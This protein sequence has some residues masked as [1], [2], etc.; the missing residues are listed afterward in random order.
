ML[1][2]ILAAVVLFLSFSSFAHAMEGSSIITIP[3]VGKSDEQFRIGVGTYVSTASTLK[4]KD[5]SMHLVGSNNYVP[6]SIELDSSGALSFVIEAKQMPKF[7]W[8]YQGGFGHESKREIDNLS[9][10]FNGQNFGAACQNACPTL[11]MNYAFANAVYRF[12]QVYIPV[13]LNFSRPDYNTTGNEGSSYDFDGR[14]GA[15]IGVG[16]T[17]TD[18]MVFELMARTLRFEAVEKTDSLEIN[19][20]TVSMTGLNFTGKYYF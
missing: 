5:A 20:E 7:G 12:D 11:T 17:A 6:A 2:R 9:I 14:F 1:S 10:T 3:T 16:L 4:A 15:Q 18:N 19:Y 8:G 13:G